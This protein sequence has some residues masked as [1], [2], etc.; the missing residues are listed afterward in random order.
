MHR[1]IPSPVAAAAADLAGLYAPHVQAVLFYG[2]CLRTGRVEG[3]VLDFYILVDCY[4]ATY[5]R[6]LK[7]LA[8]RLLPPN[9]FYR[10]L[11]H[12]GLTVRSKYAVIA[13]DDF[14]RRCREDWFN[15]SIWARFSQPVAFAIPSQENISGR[16][17]AAV[18]EAVC[19][20][21]ASAMPLAKS[22]DP[23]TLW[24]TALSLTY[25]AEL[26]SEGAQK[27]DELFEL[28]REFFDRIMP[29]ALSAIADRGGPMVAKPSAARRKWW[30][31]RICGRAVSLLR[32][33]KG[34]FTFDG[35]ID[36]LAWK[37]RRHSGVE[38]EIK[39]W[40][41]RHPIVAGLLLYLRLRRQ[42][43]FR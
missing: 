3:Q 5:G 23:K 26:R 14:E 1:E 35:G 43:A 34:A 7:A 28:N 17:T 25:G 39:P 4:S 38:I 10:E 21:L 36:Y 8:N 19:A 37:I 11:A 24:T 6:G 12:D 30:H 42:G 27:P 13:L 18:S 16:V 40:Q 31:R 15:T 2:S 9:V 20:M 22:N 32:L 33:V 29:P 41:R